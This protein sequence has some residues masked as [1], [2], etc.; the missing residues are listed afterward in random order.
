MYLVISRLQCF[1][2]SCALPIIILGV[3]RSRHHPK[4]RARLLA[5]VQQCRKYPQ[6]LTVT[7]V[8][9]KVRGRGIPPPTATSP[10]PPPVLFG[11]FLREH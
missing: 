3:V 1:S 5:I 7:G 8:A 9:E 11:V 10:A 4:H 6:H 2:W